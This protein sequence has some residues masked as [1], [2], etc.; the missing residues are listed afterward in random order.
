M[1]KRSFRWLFLSAS[2]LA[3]VGA[4]GCADRT[5]LT[6]S[7]G[8]ANNAAFSAQRAEPQRSRMQ[9]ADVTQGLDSQEAAAVSQA[10][11]KSLAGKDEG[12]ASA[13]PMVILN[14]GAGQ[15]APYVPP[16]SV[17]GGQ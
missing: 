12:A 7:H 15:Q 11:R 16:P 14:P 8:R 6:K 2:L 5:Y 17:P 13:Q 3:V 4:I 1:S 9:G 10:Y